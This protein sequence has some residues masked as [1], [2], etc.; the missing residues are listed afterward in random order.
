M[1]RRPSTRPSPFYPSYGRSWFTNGKSGF[2]VERGDK[3]KSEI[4]H[5]GDGVVR[6]VMRYADKQV[7]ETTQFEGLFQLERLDRG[8]Q[9]TIK[10]LTPLAP[11]FPLKA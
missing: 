3:Q 8:R 5:V 1:S 2:V 7:L 4:F 6:T 11:L 10:A 9:T